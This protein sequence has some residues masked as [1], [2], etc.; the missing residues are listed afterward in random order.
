MGALDGKMIGIPCAL[1]I[2]SKSLL[3]R[4]EK[5]VLY[6]IFSSKR[7]RDIKRRKVYFDSIVELFVEREQVLV[8]LLALLQLVSFGS[9]LQDVVDRRLEY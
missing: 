4:V 8:R 6:F 7:K 9:Y 5:R 3:D 1:H 2:I